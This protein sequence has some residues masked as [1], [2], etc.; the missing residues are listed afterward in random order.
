M[1]LFLNDYSDADCNREI[2]MATIQKSDDLKNLLKNEKERS[3][4]LSGMMK[5]IAQS[6]KKARELLCQMMPRE[7]ANTLLAT[8]QTGNVCE[9]FEEVTIAFAKVCDFLVLT[10]KMAAADVVNLLNNIYSHFDELVDRHGVYKVETIGESYMISAGIPYRTEFHA[11]F[12]GDA[13]LDMVATI[14]SADIDTGSKSKKV[15]MKIGVY[16]GPCVGGIVGK[17]A[18]R[19]CLFGDAVNCASRMESHNK[20]PL[21]IQIGPLTKECLERAAPGKFKFKHRGMITLKGKGEMKAYGLIGKAGRPRYQ[22]DPMVFAAVEEEIEEENLA[23][24]PIEEKDQDRAS[25]MSRMSITA[26]SR[27]SSQQRGASGSG[28]D[29]SP[30]RSGS[31]SE[32]GSNASG[33]ATPRGFDQQSGGVHGV[34]LAARLAKEGTSDSTPFNMLGGGMLHSS[35]LSS[36]MRVASGSTI[37]GN[38]A[39]QGDSKKVPAHVSKSEMV[40]DSKTYLS[41]EKKE[42]KSREKVTESKT[43]LSPERKEEK[44]SEKVPD[45]KTNLS[46]ERKEEKSGEK[47]VEKKYKSESSKSKKPISKEPL[48]FKSEKIKADKEEAEKKLTAVK[49]KQESSAPPEK[50]KSTRS[51]SKGKLEQ[52]ESAGGL[53]PPIDAPTMERPPPIKPPTIEEQVRQ[54]AREI[55][56][57]QIKSASKNLEKKIIENLQPLPPI[58]GKEIGL[59]HEHGQLCCKCDAIRKDPKLKTKVCI[60]ISI[61]KQPIAE[62]QR[63]LASVGNDSDDDGEGG[64]SGDSGIEGTDMVLTSQQAYSND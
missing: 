19:Y 17:R 41:S 16:S 37:N 12:I 47:A 45:I 20:Q 61:M 24:T 22:S 46:P 10:Q 63:E 27:G 58:E 43:N 33:G 57:A 2:I 32:H 39:L 6:K 8:G 62:K 42:E 64:M 36:S 48:K 53:T 14:K 15:A 31:P 54:E 21:T 44:S 34:A 18:P 29:M 7:V 4:V 3:M 40:P 55:V 28:E 26:Y 30:S 11:E 1:G 9:S 5:E 52:M 23:Y 50:A 38:L 35:S 13:A 56:D 51:D 59:G 49:T 25:T 60:I